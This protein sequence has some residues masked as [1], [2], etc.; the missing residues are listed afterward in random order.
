MRTDR[1]E[2]KREMCNGGMKACADSDAQTQTCGRT[3]SD[4]VARVSEPLPVVSHHITLR[5][6]LCSCA[7]RGSK[8]CSAKQSK[9]SALALW[10]LRDEPECN[11]KGRAGSI[12][13][14]ATD[15]RDRGGLSAPMCHNVEAKTAGMADEKLL[16]HICLESLL[17]A[18]RMR[19]SE[20]EL[21]GGT[22][23]E[24]ALRSVTNL[25][26]LSLGELK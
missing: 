3:R 23:V 26:F 21:D 10:L 15:E 22:S 16:S 4:T 8:A 9:A 14:K 11:G 12:K 25:P 5:A 2:T 18:C 1:K 19:A 17:K 24:A 13:R 20:P 6:L 7:A